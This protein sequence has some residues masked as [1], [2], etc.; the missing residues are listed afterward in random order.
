MTTK[1]INQTKHYSAENERIATRLEF[2]IQDGVFYNSHPVPVYY[3]GVIS[4]NE[5]RALENGFH[6]NCIW[7]RTA[8][9]CVYGASDGW[10]NHIFYEGPA[11]YFYVTTS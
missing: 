11:M 9:N 1:L 5:L 2:E 7:H 10:V 6:K 8:A 3:V 4:D